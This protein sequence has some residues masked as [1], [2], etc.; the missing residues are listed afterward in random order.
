MATLNASSKSQDLT[1]GNLNS[2]I[3]TTIEANT[4]IIC[5]CLPMLKAPLTA[6]FPNL[7]PR[8]SYQCDYSDGSNTPRRQGGRSSARNSPSAA[9][10]GW[11]R[12]VETKP[13]AHHG[14]LAKTPSG[15]EGKAST[16]TETESAFGMVCQI[17][18]LISSLHQPS[19]CGDKDLNNMCS[20][21]VFDGSL[22]YLSKQTLTRIVQDGKDVPLGSIAKTTHVKVQYADDRRFPLHPNDNSHTRSLSN[23]VGGQY[24]HPYSSAA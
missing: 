4:G 12:L 3:W 19:Q 23:L 15:W 1:Y 13:I 10:D 17:S 6:L 8:G 16:S 20:S 7:F 11:G 24:G 21:R 14:I 22:S 5:A 9:Y 2:T 18:L